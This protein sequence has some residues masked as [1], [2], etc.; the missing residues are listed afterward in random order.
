MVCRR[1]VTRAVLVTALALAPLAAASAESVSAAAATNCKGKLIDHDVAHASGVAVLELDV[2]W[3]S[4]TGKN[5]AKAV[6]LGPAYNKEA[7]TGVL[8]WECAQTTPNVSTCSPHLEEASDTGTFRFFAGPVSVHG[9][10]HC[11]DAAGAIFWNG[12]VRTASTK[13]S[14]GYEASHCG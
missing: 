10:G 5:C 3:D 14:T 1:I 11:I 2:Y 4:A 7:V 13:H 9:R 8:L 6:H 12:A